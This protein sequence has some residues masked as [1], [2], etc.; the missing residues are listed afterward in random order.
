MTMTVLHH[1]SQPLLVLLVLLLIHLVIMSSCQITST[2][3]GAEWS[4]EVAG[5]R[6]GFD[7]YGSSKVGQSF[8][9]L[10]L[11]TLEAIRVL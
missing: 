8:V 11:L 3:T 4:K 6:N 9:V 2:A 1:R 7:H 5:S 10:L